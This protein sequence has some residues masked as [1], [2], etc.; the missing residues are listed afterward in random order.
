MGLILSDA[1]PTFVC[2]SADINAN[3]ILVRKVFCW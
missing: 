1:E 2:T 3:V